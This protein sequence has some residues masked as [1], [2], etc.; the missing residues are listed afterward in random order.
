M[1]VRAVRAFQASKG[2]VVDG[3]VGP[4]TLAALFAGAAEPGPGPQNI[5][6]M[7]WYE[8]AERL[9]GTREVQGDADNPEILDWAEGL[10]IDYDDDD[11]PWCGLFVAHCV[12]STLQDEVLPSNPLG[13]RNW[14]NFGSPVDPQ[15][16]SVLVFW[17]GSPDGWKGHVGFYRGED[18]NHYYVLGGNQ[19]NSV[20][21]A[22]I[23]KNRLIGARWPLTG[24]AG[25]GQT[26]SM[27]GG[28]PVSTNEA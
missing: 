10:G 6:V 17:R 12:G 7:P 21:V 26:V 22:K 14:N 23:T 19:S 2:L 4:N 15:L 20:N 18:P 25:S 1:T 3:V 28:G 16:G 8:E 9:I 24:L 11:I 27:T 5:D 13:A